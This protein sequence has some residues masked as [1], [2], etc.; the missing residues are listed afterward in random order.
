MLSLIR[1]IV[2][3]FGGGT[4]PPRITVPTETEE[5]PPVTEAGLNRNDVIVG[6][7]TVRVPEMSKLEPEVADTV[8][9]VDG[10]IAADVTVNVPAVLPPGIVAQRQTGS[11]TGDGPAG[12]TLVMLKETN[13]PPDG[14]GWLIVTVPVDEDPP[15]TF[16]GMKLT[17]S[18]GGGSTVSITVAEPVPPI[19][20]VAVIVTCVGTFTAPATTIKL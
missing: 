10:V 12:T 2:K 19:A 9:I 15:T 8:T 17:R 6:G 7:I 1:V 18:T 3:G 20:A 4:G 16:A 14:A 11:V 13:T 5:G